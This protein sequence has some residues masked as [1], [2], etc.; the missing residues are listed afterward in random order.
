MG[1]R[2][3]GTGTTRPAHVRPPTPPAT[4]APVKILNAACPRWHCGPDVYHDRRTNRVFCP[5]CEAARAVAALARE[6][7]AA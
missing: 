6:G 1:K 7:G 3:R 2:A 5:K 4:A